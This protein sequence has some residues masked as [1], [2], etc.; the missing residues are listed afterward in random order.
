[1][2]VVY[3]RCQ[4]KVQVPF[5]YN[6]HTPSDQHSQR[7]CDSIDVAFT[8][9]SKYSVWF[10]KCFHHLHRFD[11]EV[12]RTRLLLST[13]ANTRLKTQVL[14]LF[15]YC[16]TYLLFLC[17]TNNFCFASSAM[18]QE[19]ISSTIVMRTRLISKKLMAAVNLL[20][21]TLDSQE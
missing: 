12:R 14:C 5:T 2:W 11:H 10:R 7:C 13:N 19:S 9:V 20:P 4:N 8:L 16:T 3:S 18:R 1:M 15:L 17:S 21:H 6:G